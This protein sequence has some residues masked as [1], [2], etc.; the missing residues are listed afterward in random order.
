[1]AVPT[2]V[3]AGVAADAGVDADG[4]TTGE[5]DIVEAVA[6]YPSLLRA[7]GVMPDTTVP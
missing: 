2:E 1:M 7:A 4:G 6:A 3:G 5:P